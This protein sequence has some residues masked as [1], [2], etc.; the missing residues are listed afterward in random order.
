MNESESTVYSLWAKTKEFQWKIVQARRIA[1]RGFDTMYPSFASLSFGK[2][3]MAMVH[4][5]LAMKPDLPVMYVNCGKWDEWPDTSRVKAE[6]LAQFS[7]DFTELRGP[8]VIEGYREAE[9]FIQDEADSKEARKAQH[10]YGKSL[11]EILDAEARRRRY[12]GAFIGV[13]K[14]ESNNRSRLFAMRGPLYYAETRGLWACHPLAYWSARDVW[15]YIVECNLPYNELYDL[16]P[17]GREKARNGAMFGTR[18]A[19]YGR[20]VFLRQMYPDWFN[21]FAAEFPGV[22]NYV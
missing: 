3:S 7:C 6:F 2:D 15:A 21:R 16:D 11:G 22:R 20:L 9:L 14:D 5:L 17:R 1:E 10:D 12:H 8:S 18:S 13:R 4:L 19:R